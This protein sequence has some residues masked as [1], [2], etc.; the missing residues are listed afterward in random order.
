MIHEIETERVSIPQVGDIRDLLCSKI[1]LTEIQAQAND[2][3]AGNAFVSPAEVIQVMNPTIE[4]R[5]TT[6]KEKIL[7]GPYEYL[8]N[9]PG[10][11]IRSQ[12][13]SAFNLWLRV[14]YDS[15]EV[16]RRVVTMLHTASLL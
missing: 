5:W 14:P 4:P 9:Q 7:L 6:D 10:K 3:E 2:N 1:S 16:I 13:I 8:S 11:N 15:L 12:F